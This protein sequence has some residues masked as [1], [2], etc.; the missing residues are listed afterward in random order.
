MVQSSRV[1][2]V[3]LR[4]SWPDAGGDLVLACVFTEN[5]VL[6]QGTTSFVSLCLIDWEDEVDGDDL[7]M[8]E[9]SFAR[10]VSSAGT[11]ANRMGSVDTESRA[12]MDFCE[13][14]CAG[15]KSECLPRKR[16]KR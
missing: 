1:I 10:T 15:Y 8:K 12:G 3:Q 13:C 2:S 14:G 5:L 7:S 4:S 6:S 11:W 16:C 9:V